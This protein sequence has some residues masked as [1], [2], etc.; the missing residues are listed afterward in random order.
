[1]TPRELYYAQQAISGVSGNAL[2]FLQEKCQSAIRHFREVPNPSVDTNIL[3][4]P[5]HGIRVWSGKDDD[6]K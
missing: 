2:D 1:M 4:R 6:G 5:V 3:R